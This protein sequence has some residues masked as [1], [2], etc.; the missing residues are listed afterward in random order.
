MRLILLGPPG[1]GKGTQGPRIA[2]RCEIARISTG[3]MLR[4][5][6]RNGTAI[7]RLAKERIDRGLLVPDDDMIELVEARLREPDCTAGFVL[8]GFPRTRRQAVA[9]DGFLG[10]HRLALDGV[11]DLQV[12]DAELIRRL[13]GRRVCPQCGATFHLETNPPQEADRC[14]CD[15]APLYQREDD[16]PGSI[17]QRMEIYRNDTAPLIDYYQ[18]EGLLRPIN[19]D[20]PPREVEEQIDREMARLNGKA[21]GS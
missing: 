5:A 13:S 10:D 12:K 20:A 15:G 4:E 8:D 7:G 3:D 1:A 16:K 6:A 2:A 21:D 17:S 14:D 9:L 18:R 19:G 11:L